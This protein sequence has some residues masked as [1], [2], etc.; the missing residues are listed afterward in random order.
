MA[1]CPDAV[2]TETSSI[3]PGNGPRYSQEFDCIRLNVFDGALEIEG[4][5]DL[6]SWALP[7]RSP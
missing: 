1:T 5:L 6:L 3:S 7:L 4:V 2:F